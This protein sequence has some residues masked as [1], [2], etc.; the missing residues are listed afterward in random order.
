MTGHRPFTFDTEFDD[1]GAVAY[2]P[3]RQKR[4]FTPEE[5]ETI[6]A[7]AYA[8]PSTTCWRCGLT[9][10]EVQ[11]TGKRVTWHSGHV[12]D[13]DARSPLRA[14]HSTCNQS[15]GATAGRVRAGLNPSRR[16]Y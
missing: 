10:A 12:I 11:R 2:Q 16:W 14:E 3:P 7:A 9:L 15:A 5:V 8:D 6:R 13:G 1:A 4:S